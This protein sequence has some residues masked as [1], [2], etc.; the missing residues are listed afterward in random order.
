MNRFDFIKW[1]TIT[2]AIGIL[3]AYLWATGRF[4]PL[5]EWGVNLLKSKTE[6]QINKIEGSHEKR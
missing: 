5:V 2:T 6:Q 3:I 1:V 4:D